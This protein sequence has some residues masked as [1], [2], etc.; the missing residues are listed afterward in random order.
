MRTATTCHG[1][2]ETLFS[3]L[4]TR[5]VYMELD[6]HV[7]EPEAYAKHPQY[8]VIGSTCLD[9]RSAGQA[10]LMLWNLHNGYTLYQSVVIESCRHEIDS[11]TAFLSEC[12][13]TL[14]NDDKADTYY[15]LCVR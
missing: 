14:W 1:H 6:R 11:S 2:L 3:I 15:E 10:A 9:S 4:C 13:S 12:T 8:N 7:D 5:C